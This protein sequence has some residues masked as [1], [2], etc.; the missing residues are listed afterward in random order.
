MTASL[1]PHAKLS[2]YEGCGHSVFF[3]AAE[4]FN[5]ELLS[6]VDQVELIRSGA[7]PRRAVHVPA[8]RS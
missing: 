1:I 4:R 2:L 8:G 5:G 6:F 3:E 7:M